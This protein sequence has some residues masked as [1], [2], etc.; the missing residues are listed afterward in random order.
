LNE[1]FDRVTDRDGVDRPDAAYRSRV[2]LEV[3]DEATSGTV[4]PR[5]RAQLSAGHDPLFDAG[6][7]GR[8]APSDRPETEPERV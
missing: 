6:S 3:V 1:L 7:T 2:V 4:L 8:M 5:V